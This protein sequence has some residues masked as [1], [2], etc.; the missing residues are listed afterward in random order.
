[1]FFWQII[2]FSRQTGFKRYICFTSFYST[3][4]PVCPR[5][6][7][8]LSRIPRILSRN[9]G[10]THCHLCSAIRSY[11][12]TNGKSL[13]IFKGRWPWHTEEKGVIGLKRIFSS[14]SLFFFFC[15]IPVGIFSVLLSRTCLQLGGKWISLL[16][17]A[18]LGII[19]QDCCWLV[20][21]EIG[22][23]WSKRGPAGNGRGFNIFDFLLYKCIYFSSNL[24]PFF[25]NLPKQL[26]SKR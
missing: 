10:A 8:I 7:M 20:T 14:V 2:C 9:S 26:F 18:N 17:P 25:S 15:E 22:N 13:D 24:P 16:S 3:H 19:S 5:I 6:P 12:Q 4:G 1:M 21:R 11:R 23:I